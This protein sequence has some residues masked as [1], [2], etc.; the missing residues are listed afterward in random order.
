M[1][2]TKKIIFDKKN[3]VY[4]FEYRGVKIWPLG[5]D[6]L[7]KAENEARLLKLLDQFSQGDIDMIDTII[8]NFAERKFHVCYNENYMETFNRSVFPKFFELENSFSVN[9]DENK[10]NDKISLWA[11]SDSGLP[12]IWERSGSKTGSPWE[13]GTRPKEKQ[14]Q[15]PWDRKK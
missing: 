4:G 8:A 6:Y 11:K 5:A 12:E 13:S 2:K 10:N 9:V 15:S 7:G 3:N 14:S 1:T